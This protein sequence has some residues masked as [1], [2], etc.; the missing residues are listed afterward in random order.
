MDASLAAKKAASTVVLRAD[1]TVEISAV[2]L[3]A[4]KAE[5]RAVSRVASTAVS[6]AVLKVV[7]SAATKAALMVVLRADVMVW[8]SVDKLVVNY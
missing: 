7:Y 6:S 3:V 4:W 5:K 8:S 2:D 1:M